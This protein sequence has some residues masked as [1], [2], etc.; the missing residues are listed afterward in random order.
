MGPKRHNKDFS[1]M[2]ASVPPSLDNEVGSEMLRRPWLRRIDPEAEGVDTPW[3]NGGQGSR[4]F[5]EFLH[6]S[7]VAFGHRHAQLVKVV[8]QF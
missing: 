5:C 8:G 6:G 1:V 3:L 2:L 4:Q 7:P